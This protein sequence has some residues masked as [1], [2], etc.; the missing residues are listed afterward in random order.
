[1]SEEA[2][3]GRLVLAVSHDLM[4]AARFA[5]RVLVLNEGRQIDFGAPAGVLTAALMREVFGVETRRISAGADALEI[6][7]TPAVR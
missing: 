2:K 3:S 5:D 4:L 1:M 6:P 7:W